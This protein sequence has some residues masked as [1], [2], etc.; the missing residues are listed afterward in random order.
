MTIQIEGILEIDQD[1]GVI[2]F[3]SNETGHSPLRI[4]S[5]PKPIPNPEEYANTL[6]ITHMKGCSWTGK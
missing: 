1:R 3:H 2:Y 6:D 4:C 5:L